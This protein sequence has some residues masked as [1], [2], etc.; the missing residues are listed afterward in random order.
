MAGGFEVFAQ[1][2]RDE[3]RVRLP[4]HLAVVFVITRNDVSANS[5]A[6]ETLPAE[7]DVLVET[8]TREHQDLSGNLFGLVLSFREVVQAKEIAL[9][10]RLG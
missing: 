3:L 1:T 7:L 10:H 6:G 8:F 2:I 5:I 4:H 9:S